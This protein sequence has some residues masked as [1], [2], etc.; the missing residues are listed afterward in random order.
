MCRMAS[1]Y[2]ASGPV[3]LKC[4]KAG[5]GTGRGQGP[6]QLSA[7][8]ASGSGDT[9]VSN[10]DPLVFR[11]G[12]IS[13]VAERPDLQNGRNDGKLGRFR[14]EVKVRNETS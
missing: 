14:S 11:T 4:R 3:V 13:N 6:R 1:D 10:G 12:S 7:C 5:S 8:P 2:K 9:C